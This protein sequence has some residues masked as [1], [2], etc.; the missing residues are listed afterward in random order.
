MNPSLCGGYGAYSV[1]ASTT[2]KKL[3]ELFVY[4]D[5]DSM[6]GGDFVNDV[7]TVGGITVDTMKMGIVAEH[8]INANTLILGYGNASS[9]S[10]TQALADAGAIM[11]PAFIN[12]SGPTKALLINM[13]G[14]SINMDD[15]SINETSAT[16]KEFPLDAVLDTEIGMIYVPKSV[17]Q[18]LNAQIGNTSVP[19][20][21]GQVNFS[22]SAVGENS[23]INFKFGELDFIFYLSYFVS[24]EMEIATYGG[25]DFR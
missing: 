3:D 12:R 14:M 16:S 18:A 22:Y 19:D 11:S 2:A 15:I 21:R 9:T 8:K 25:V 10:L 24:Q 23:T 6:T 7:L 5:S 4:D 17:A 20:K 1:A 13:D